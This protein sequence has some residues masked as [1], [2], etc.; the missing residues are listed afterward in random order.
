MPTSSSWLVQTISVLI[1]I[2]N[3][4]SDDAFIEH[5]F[6]VFVIKSSNKNTVIL[7]LTEN[8]KQFWINVLKNILFIFF[9]PTIIYVL[10][11][12]EKSVHH[13]SLKHK[14]LLNISIKLLIQTLIHVCTQRQCSYPLASMIIDIINEIYRNVVWYTYGPGAPNDAIH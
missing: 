9:I 8:K 7:I 3:L 11:F 13:L 4:R 10:T 2:R 5:L 1:F 12:K 14:D 6:C